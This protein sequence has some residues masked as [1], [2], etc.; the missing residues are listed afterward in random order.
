MITVYSPD[1]TLPRKQEN[2]IMPFTYCIS[3]Y[4][5]GTV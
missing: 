3:K 4:G 2:T 5:S 1:E